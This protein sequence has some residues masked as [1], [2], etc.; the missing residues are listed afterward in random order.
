VINGIELACAPH[1]WAVGELAL[2]GEREWFGDRVAVSGGWQGDD[3]IAL[4][5]VLEDAVTFRIRVSPSGGLT[6]T[7][8]VG[9]DGPDVWSGEPATTAAGEVASSVS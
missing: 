8:D 1:E 9:F 4:L 5:R 6:I 3:F 7:R 2:D